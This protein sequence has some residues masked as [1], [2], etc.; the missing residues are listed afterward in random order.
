MK[1]G[2][3]GDTETVMGFGLTGIGNTFQVSDPET[4]KKAFK[5]ATDEELNLGI[6]IITEG[7][8][9]WLAA[10]LKY[11]RRQNMLFPIIIE[12]PDKSGPRE[13]PDPITRLIR[14]AVGVDIS[15]TR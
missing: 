4:A 12:I 1:V 11:W 15:K 2:I 8:A 14:R 7:I 9:D 13:R 10:E 3:I 6:L 5:E